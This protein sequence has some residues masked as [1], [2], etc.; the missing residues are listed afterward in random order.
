MATKIEE[1]TANLGKGCLGKAADDE[2]VFILRA[3]D[4][5]APATIRYW[6]Q[7]ARVAGSPLE[8]VHKALDLADEMVAWQ[9]IHGSKF[10]D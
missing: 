3:H 9:N 5:T 4:E 2:P 8:K 7:K 10:P 6:A 1:L